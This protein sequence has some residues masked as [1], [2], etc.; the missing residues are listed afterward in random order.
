MYR[1]AV[2]TE[3]SF[4][5]SL[6]SSHRAVVRFDHRPT[7]AEVEEVLEHNGWQYSLMLDFAVLAGSMPEQAWRDALGEPPTRAIEITPASERPGME[8]SP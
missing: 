2:N 1:H 3:W 5:S 8:L 6:H 4:E 7:A